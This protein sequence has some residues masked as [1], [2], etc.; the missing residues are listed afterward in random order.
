[1]VSIEK[2]LLT[3]GAGGIGFLIP[4][5]SLHLLLQGQQL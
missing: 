3:F 4:F 2:P 1:M 5:T